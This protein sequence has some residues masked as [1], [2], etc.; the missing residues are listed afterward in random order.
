MPH[1]AP[2]C[3]DPEGGDTPELRVTDQGPGIPPEESA[4]LFRKFSRLSTRPTG[5]ESSSGLGLAIARGIIDALGG[6][7]WCESSVGK[8]ATFCFSLPPAT[9]EKARVN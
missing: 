3:A 5:G 1:P 6:R 2:R 9:A 4:R 8:G 7:I